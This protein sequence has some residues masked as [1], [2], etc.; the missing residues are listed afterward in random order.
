[1]KRL[2]VIAASLVVA[3]FSAGAQNYINF[4]YALPTMTYKYGDT[5]AE[6]SDSNALFL[7]FSHNFGL[8]GNF[9]LEAGL[10]GLYD[11]KKTDLIGEVNAKS[12]YIGLQV[13]ALF[14]Y[15]IDLAR[16]CAVKLFLGPTFAFGLSNKVKSGTDKTNYTIDYYEDG[17]YNRFGAS[18]SAAAA[19]EW[20]NVIRLKI[21]YDLGLVD[22][23]KSDNIVEK[24]NALV[25]SLGYM[26]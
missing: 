10:N 9:G 22:L 1:M 23:N 18:A 26:F 5:K 11:F 19:L 3:A 4:G 15:K 14:N 25:F 6:S 20:A 17:S 7:G 2:F 21:G 16:D 13:P 12:Q 24:Q 8:S